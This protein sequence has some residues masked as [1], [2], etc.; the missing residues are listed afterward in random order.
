MF[1]KPA[2]FPGCT[3]NFAENLLYPN[4]DLDPQ[5]PAIIAATE[6][7]RATVTWT[8]LRERV[9]AC[10][11]AMKASNVRQGDR[12]AGYLAN[13]ANTVVAMLAATSLGAMWTGVSP[14]TGVHA[15]LDRLKQ[16]EPV[17]LFADNA[18]TYNGKTHETHTKISQIA[19]ELPSVKHLVIFDTVPAH[20]FELNSLETHSNT[21]PQT[22]AQFT[23]SVAI[24][25]RL[26][27][28]SLPPDHPVYILYSSGTTGAPKPIVHG[29]LGTLLQHK[30]EHTLQCDVRPGDRLYYFTTCES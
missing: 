16:V 8:E 19:S 22:Y 18:V 21:S 30:K 12:V 9:G 17:I 5:S 3:L 20:P 7:T 26:H 29:A 10:A 27:F 15:V 2:F 13:H 25:E 14:D 4:T 6:T 23:S 1:P 11:A 24:N 28:A